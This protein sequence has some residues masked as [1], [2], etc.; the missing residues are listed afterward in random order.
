MEKIGFNGKWLDAGTPI[1]SADNRGLR[2]G[3]GVFETM[4]L[5]QGRIPLASLHFDRLFSALD[6]LG[7]EPGPHFTREKLE[8]EILEL[9]AKNQHTQLARVRLMVFRGDGGL[10]EGAQSLNY[11]IQSWALHESYQELNSNGLVLDIFPDARK[12]TDPFSNLKSANFLPYVMAAHYARKNRLNDCLVLNTHDR[13]ADSTIANLFIF[14]EGKYITPPLAEGCVAGVMRRYLLGRLPAWGYPV[15]EMPVTIQ[16]L[17]NA[18]HVFLSN[19][20]RGIQWVGRFGKSEFVQ[21]NT[22]E[23]YNNWRC[24][25]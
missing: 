12:S 4:R 23:I 18:D 5:E 25:K 10:Y 1:A 20:V 16:D 3:D 11:S 17:E 6:T 8:K 9:A 22:K 24:E 19:A 7:F 21:G 2:Y 15:V 14:K 13:I